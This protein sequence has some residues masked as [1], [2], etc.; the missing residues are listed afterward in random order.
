LTGDYQPL[1]RSGFGPVKKICQRLWN[2]QASR[3]PHLQW[4]HRE[5]AKILEVAWA[6]LSVAV[7]ESA[8]RFQECPSGLTRQECKLQFASEPF[9]VEN[10]DWREEEE[11]SRADDPPYGL[12]DYRRD[13][14]AQSDSDESEPGSTETL[15]D[16]YGRLD[17]SRTRSSARQNVDRRVLSVDIPFHELPT[18]GPTW[19]GKREKTQEEKNLQ[20][21]RAN[22][23]S[24]APR[25][26]SGPFG[27]PYDRPDGPVDP[28]GF[29]FAQPVCH[30]RGE[31]DC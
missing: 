6:Q 14:A 16:Q 11:K 20:K 1:D 27:R 4:T 2:Q 3:E 7:L 25:F 15:V 28:K 24:F 30:R 13:K 26:S 10:W 17:L 23:V 29:L 5:A 12:D 9:D 18:C 19:T 22:L 31:P 21:A 8:W